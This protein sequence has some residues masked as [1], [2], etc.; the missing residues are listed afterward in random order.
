MKRSVISTDNAKFEQM[1]A[2]AASKL[3]MT[4]EQLKKAAQSGNTDDILSHMDK[5]SADKIRSALSDKALTERLS[6]KFGK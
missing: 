6:E 4:P 5:A 2:L 3:N 1:L